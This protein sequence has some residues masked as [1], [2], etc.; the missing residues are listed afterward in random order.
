MKDVMAARGDDERLLHL[1]DVRDL[2]LAERE[3]CAK[4]ADDLSRGYLQ[5][6]AQAT[7]NDI[8]K[9]IRARGA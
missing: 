3:A 7:A 1:H 6:V 9:Q 2:L 4:I 8:A 5:E